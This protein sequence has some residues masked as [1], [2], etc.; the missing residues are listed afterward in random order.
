MAKNKPKIFRGEMVP[1]F[2]FR[3]T[4]YAVLAVL[5]LYAASGGIENQFIKIAINSIVFL[6]LPGSII[7]SWLFGS[8]KFELAEKIF[9]TFVFSLIFNFFP[10]IASYI[11]E[12]SVVDLIYLLGFLYLILILIDL[13]RLQDGQKKIKLEFRLDLKM[14]LVFLIGF[15]FMAVSFKLGSYIG[16]DARAHMAIIRKNIFDP[17]INSNSTHYIDGG[18]YWVYAYS[19]WHPLL[20]VMAKLSSPTVIDFW[21]RFNFVLA[22]LPFL[23]IYSLCKRLFLNRYVAFASVVILALAFVLNFV[24]RPHIADFRL[25]PMPLG[26]SLYILLP[27]MF[28][29][30]FAYLREKRFLW[31]VLIGLLALVI[32]SIHVYYLILFFLASGAFFIG[33]LIARKN[34]QAKSVFYIFL[35]I[36]IIA[37][38]FLIFRYLQVNVNDPEQLRLKEYFQENLIRINSALYI[39]HPRVLFMR[40]GQSGLNWLPILAYALLPFI[41]IWRRNK[42][43]AI[44]IISVMLIVPLIIFNPYLAVKL[45]E[46]ISPSKVWRMYQVVPTVPVLAY[47]FFAFY[48]FISDRSKI[49]GKKIFNALLILL[50]LSFAFWGKSF[51][52]NYKVQPSDKKVKEA[53]MRSD[54]VDILNNKIP[55]D[56]VILSDR[57]TSYFIP[58][59]S[60]QFVVTD[61]PGLSVAG[62]L[63]R[64]EKGEDLLQNMLASRLEKKFL[65]DNQIGYILF[66]TDRL[67][68]KYLRILMNKKTYHL[69]YQ[70][71][72]YYIFEVN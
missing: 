53:E 60:S 50:I 34:V 46:S 1:L 58:V 39:V 43:W 57:L 15:V 37:G 13:V 64:Q 56:S 26:I 38:G 28:Y 12:L 48:K 33:L 61:G 31:L 44:F 23:A 42:L 70:K 22:P 62:Q 35:A 3:G 45:S 19:I 66:R 5:F 7:F 59:F 2:V 32:T 51:A 8:Q 49:E 36:G 65:Q 72:P 18:V 67:D 16:S 11:F 10:V 71:S 4:F 27:A 9:L 20:A 41:F 14:I 6:F 29:F 63:A 68:K 21:Q 25:L 52:H 17:F 55:Q 47:G 24:G 30:S 54:I 40:I 69:I